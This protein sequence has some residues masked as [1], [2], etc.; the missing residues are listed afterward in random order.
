[1]KKITILLT[2]FFICA[3][4]FSK[5]IMICGSYKLSGYFDDGTPYSGTISVTKTDKGITVSGDLSGYYSCIGDNGSDCVTYYNKDL[6]GITFCANG[7]ISISNLKIVVKDN[8]SLSGWSTKTVNE[9]S[10]KRI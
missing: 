7:S 4:S 2:L 9:V 6:R 5:E 8:H 1:M 3:V 10:G